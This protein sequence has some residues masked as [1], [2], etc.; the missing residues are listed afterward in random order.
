MKEG[1]VSIAEQVAQRVADI[2][3]APAEA[4][5]NE[6]VFTDYEFIKACFD[7]SERGDGL[8]LAELLAGKALFVN[9]PDMKGEWYIWDKHV[10][11]PDADYNMINLS[12]CVAQAYHCYA[13]NIESEFNVLKIALEQEQDEKRESV[14]SSDLDDEAKKKELERLDKQGLD[15]PK[16]MS[17]TIK[18]FRKRAFNLKKRENIL[19]AM[20]FAPKVNDALKVDQKKLDQKHHLLPCANG[21]IDLDR[22]VL[23]NGHPDDLLTKN[24][25]VSYDPKIDYSPWTKIVE[26]ICIHPNVPGSEDLPKFI[27]TFF[28]Y[29]IS[30]FTDE[31]LLCIFFG[32]GRNGKGTIIESVTKLAGPYFHKVNRSLFVEQKYEPSPS[33]ASE[34]LRALQG[35][36][37]VVGAETNKGQKIDSGRIK[38]L[39]GNNTINFR[40]N[41]GAEETFDPTHT[42]FL[43]T[44][45]HLRGITEEF[46]MIERL[47]IIDV[48][49]RFVD[50]VEEHERKFPALKGH[51]KKKDKKLKEKLKTP[52][53]QKMIL[54]W[55]VDGYKMWK[56]NGLVIPACCERSRDT[57]ADNEDHVKRFVNEVLVA[58]P[59][60]HE[61]NLR[62]VRIPLKLLYGKVFKWWW[63]ENL[64]GN[65]DQKT[66]KHKNTLSSYLED[67]G[68]EKVRKGGDIYFYHVDI[69]TEIKHAHPELSEV[70]QNYRV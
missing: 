7:E 45:N 41:F 15:I 46:S 22:G 60:D 57:L 64:G 68:Y 31:E 32:P 69:C 29:A 14:R 3:P 39:T 59:T 5:V 16:W 54:K 61:G 65:G 34:H 17:G 37:I 8:L 13:D 56:D 12:D 27:Q 43:E 52:D 44:N 55:L 18:E 38:D 21:V 33:A 11:R 53:Y 47:A 26:D 62:K 67:N 10:W 50:S 51:F 58:K 20:F 30:G 23:V 4:M 70:V 6:D 48:P 9:A 25:E 2:L 19:K 1:Q 36:R 40:K 42:I 63:E 35:K 49:W 24:I 28:G 66:M